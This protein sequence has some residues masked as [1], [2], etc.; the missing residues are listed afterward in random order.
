MWATNLIEHGYDV[1]DNMFASW[2]VH[3]WNSRL[4]EISFV[5][6]CP[7]DLCYKDGI[8]TTAYIHKFIPIARASLAIHNSTLH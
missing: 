7:K 3:T 5:V 2:N 4:A 1:F 6:A 8:K